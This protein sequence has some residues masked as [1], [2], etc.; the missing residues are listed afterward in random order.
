MVPEQEKAAERLTHMEEICVLAS[1]L[2]RRLITFSTGGDPI[3]RILT[4]SG[5]LTDTVSLMLKGSNINLLL[6]LPDDLH[7]V[8]IDQGQMKQ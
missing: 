2:S 6:E 1:E 8:D 4:L 3:K 5:V 7:A